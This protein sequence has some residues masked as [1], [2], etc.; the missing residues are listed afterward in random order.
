MLLLW[1]L[2]RLHLNQDSGWK[3]WMCCTG[4]LSKGTTWGLYVNQH[5]RHLSPSSTGLHSG[6]ASVWGEV[7]R[8]LTQQSSPVGCYRAQVTGSQP[9]PEQ[10]C[11]ALWAV[12]GSGP[13]CL[14]VSVGTCIFSHVIGF[15]V[16][17]AILCRGSNNTEIRTKSNKIKQCYI[18][19]I[20]GKSKGKGAHA[21]NELLLYFPS[22]F[23]LGRSG[24]NV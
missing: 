2:K 17:A 1:Q 23:L 6:P 18:C 10:V 20:T 24:M 3:D 8:P 21:P 11:W 14:V 16:R 19:G 9:C 4:G 12:G 7:I 5:F 22:F 15:S 13:Q